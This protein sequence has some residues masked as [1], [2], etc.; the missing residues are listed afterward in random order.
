MNFLEAGPTAKE[1]PYR[2]SVFWVIDLAGKL[3]ECS[4]FDG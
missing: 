4:V 1:Q 3:P 2:R